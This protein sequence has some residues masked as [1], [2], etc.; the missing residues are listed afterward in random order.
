MSQALANH[1]PGLGSG[2]KAYWAVSLAPTMYYVFTTRDGRSLKVYTIGLDRWGSDV[3]RGD[4]K[5]EGDLYSY[6]RA[7]FGHVK[8]ETPTTCSSAGG[9]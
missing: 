3:D 2:R 9:T 8:V 6:L 7:V 5:V 4:L 1:F